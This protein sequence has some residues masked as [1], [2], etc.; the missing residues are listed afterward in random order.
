MAIGFHNRISQGE[1]G[2]EKL[3][4]KNGIYSRFGKRALDICVVLLSLGRGMATE[5]MAISA[6]SAPWGSRC[7]VSNAA[8]V[9]STLAVFAAAANANL[10]WYF[11]E[12]G[13][14]G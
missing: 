10:S 6:K 5:E 11:I 1:I 9:R 3:D 7:L 8:Q 13:S 2:G 12:V 14:D 4:T